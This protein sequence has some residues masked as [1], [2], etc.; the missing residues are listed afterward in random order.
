MPSA[1]TV[2][3]SPVTTTGTLTVTGAGNTSQYISGDGSLITFPISGQAGTLVKIVRNQTGATLT[4]GTAVY[5]SGATGNNP[6][7]SK[8]LATG[9][10]TSAQ[11]FGLLQAD[12][13]NNAEGYAVMIGRLETLDTSAF[14]VGQQLYLSSTVAGTYTATKQYAPAHLVYVGIIIRSHPTLGEIEVKIQNGYELG[15]LHNVAA[16][17]GSS[18]NNDG[19]FWETSTQLWKNK[20]IATVLGYTPLQN[21]Q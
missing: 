4:K 1:F 21:N 12:I 20:S 9:D 13:A 18:N 10:I 19:L 2:T 16:V 7:V 8:A 14:T 17:N 11:T 3:N 15:E 5:I 6:L